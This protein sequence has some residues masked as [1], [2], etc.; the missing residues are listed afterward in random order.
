MA[1]LRNAFDANQSKIKSLG[2][3]PIDRGGLKREIL[4]ACKAEARR[5]PSGFQGLMLKQAGKRT[6]PHSGVIE[7]V[8]T[9]DI[10]LRPG[11]RPLFSQISVSR[12]FQRHQTI[13]INRS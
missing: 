4:V 11:R 2:S 7:S 1:Q 5:K 13:H 10:C 9:L 8:D 12:S 6:A 3:G